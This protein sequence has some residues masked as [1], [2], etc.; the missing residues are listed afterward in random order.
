MPARAWGVD[1][2]PRSIVDQVTQSILDSILSCELPPGEEV[3]IL[4]LSERL[5][6][7]H[8]PV[9]EALRRLESRGFVVFRRGKPPQIAPVDR[10]DFEDLF[11]LRLIVERDVARRSA[12]LLT[13]E[14]IQWLEEAFADLEAMVERGSVVGTHRLHTEFHRALLPGA[15][16]WDRQVLDQVWAAT[17]RYVQVY[18]SV[19]ER[20]AATRQSIVDEHRR[21]VE[22][23]RDASPKEFE[24][25]VV[26]HVQRSCIALRPAI[27][28]ASGRTV[29]APTSTRP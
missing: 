7:S 15:S 17:E 22:A 21:L 18:S 19:V 12:K 23:A 29:A 8:I 11:Q 25:A 6:V 1:S 27:A 4:D 26:D 13:P 9:R 16:R 3:A 2:A 24:R 20:D 14:R 28:A 5:G 10:E